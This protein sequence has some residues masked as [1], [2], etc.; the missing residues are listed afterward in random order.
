[1]DI[2][3]YNM[4]LSINIENFSVVWIILT[5]GTMVFN[6]CN[7]MPSMF[8]LLAAGLGML[9]KYKSFSK[10]N[11]CICVGVLAVVG[12]STLMN[13]I[14]R[15]VIN[16]LFIMLIR[17]FSLI[18]IMSNVDRDCFK[19]VYINTIYIIALISIPCFFWVVLVPSATL[20]FT[21]SD[22]DS[23]FYGT[24]YYTLGTIKNGVFRRNSGIFWEPGLFQIYLNYALALLIVD[25]ENSVKRPMVKFV[26]MSI[27]VLTTMSTM[28]YICYAIIIT[29]AVFARNSGKRRK[30]II[31]ALISLVLLLLVENSTHLIEDKLLNRGQSFGTRYDDTLITLMM[32]KEKPLLGWGPVS[33]HVS[34]FDTYVNTISRLSRDILTRSNGLAMFSAK[35]GIPMT[36]IYLYLVYRN[37]M[38]INETSK[39]NACLILLI[40]ICGFCNEP[41]MFTTLWLS[42]FF[43]WKR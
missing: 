16:D 13:G 39:I 40:L 27:A 33:D 25:K 21:I 38:E 19:K 20:P 7:M 6:I 11:L 31:F 24:F 28:G 18:M 10:K 22:I 8:I 23:G 4:R 37:N 34:V 26:V 1:M 29:M 42:F 36:I 12:V 3:L 5:S 35:F 15:I 2:K 14:D 32:L 30:L 17:F 41:I 9:Y 43:C